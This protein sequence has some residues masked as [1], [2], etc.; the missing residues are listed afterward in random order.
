MTR[1][2]FIIL[3]TLLLLVVCILL[4]LVATTHGPNDHKNGFIRQG[5]RNA[6]VPTLHE[7]ALGQTLYKICGAT[8]RRF[9]FTGRDPRRI[10]SADMNMEHVDSLFIPFPLTKRMMV[11]WDLKID[12]PPDQFVCQ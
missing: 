4:S 10:F 3:G 7:L 2:P 5:L 12:S 1:K 6:V 9:F 8:S 11:A